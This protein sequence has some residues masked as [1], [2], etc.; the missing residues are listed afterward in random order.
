MEGVKMKYIGGIILILTGVLIISVSTAIPNFTVV[1]A[2][3]SQ[4][5]TYSGLEFMSPNSTNPEIYP[6][7]STMQLWEYFQTNYVFYSV[8]FFD[9]S[10][11]SLTW[12][13]VKL[14]IYD[15][16][17]HTLVG[18]YKVNDVS[19][20]A[21]NRYVTKTTAI[22][23]P[24]YSILVAA[25]FV[26]N[27]PN[28]GENHVYEFIWSSTLHYTGTFGPGQ[29]YVNGTI[30][31]STTPGFGK[32]TPKTVYPGYFVLQNCT[33]S[34]EPTTIQYLDRLNIQEINITIPSSQKYTYL[35]FI[36]VKYNYSGNSLTNFA[37]AY[38][39]IKKANETETKWVLT[40]ST[41]YNNYPALYMH[42]KLPPGKYIIK[43]YA[44]Y[45]TNIYG[46]EGNKNIF[47]MAMSINIVSSEQPGQ[48][49]INNN[50]IINYFVGF[51]LVI[52]GVVDVW[53]WHI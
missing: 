33:P 14:T 50:Q 51:L 22:E 40:N 53:R 36:Y 1:N 13:S 29:E 23:Y 8:E 42:M 11:H 19:L 52:I 44:V 15:Y 38:I 49:L 37:G 25:Y 30:S 18:T 4:N 12:A 7:T 35:N 2:N 46:A 9:S 39:M 10:Y 21:T 5:V 6:S 17:T 16:T 43:G 31:T 24:Y 27:N 32:F 48:I 3:L 20:A 41:T 47:D 34:W 26:F 45:N 28:P